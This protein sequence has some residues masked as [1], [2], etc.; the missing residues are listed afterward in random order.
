MSVTQIYLVG[1]S[2]TGK[3]TL[4]DALARR[5]GWDYLKMSAGEAYRRHGATFESAEADPALLRRVQEQIVGD[6]HSA[7]ALATAGGKPFV[8]ERSVDYAAYTALLTDPRPLAWARVDAMASFLRQA[9]ARVF[10]VRP[11]P[12]ILD[13]ARAADGGRR[14]KFLADPWVYG[15]DG[16]IMMYLKHQNVPFAEVGP[17]SAEDRVAF[18]LKSAGL[19]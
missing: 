12:E 10:F 16:A 1:S 6:A 13:R 19:A 4:A 3:S 8:A 18:V 15:V 5:L 11:V 9:R 2:G 14:S 7:I 17:G